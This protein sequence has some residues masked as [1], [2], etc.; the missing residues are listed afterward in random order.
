MSKNYVI[1]IARGFGSGGKQTA[2]QIGEKLGIPVYE[3]QILEMASAYS[4]LSEEMF[5]EVDEKLRGN[6]VTN[7]LAKFTFPKEV[8][9]TSKRFESDIN[10]FCIQAE[11]IK[12]LAQNVSCVIIGKCADHIL[13]DFDN[14][15]SFY[16]EAP[17]KECLESIMTKTGVNEKEVL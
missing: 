10:L 13:K 17:R 14:V 11:I 2:T 9:P 7:A 6:Y 12:Q 1:T 4:G 8:S 5:I 15:A 3:K 16:I